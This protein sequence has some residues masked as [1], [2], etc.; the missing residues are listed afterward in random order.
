MNVLKLNN[1]AVNLGAATAV[2]PFCIGRE[3]VAVNFTAGAL[4]VQG[5]DDGTNYTT[6]VTVPTI[7][8]IQIPALPRYVKV[9]TAADVYLLGGV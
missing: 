7:G 8:M 9:S 5:S 6:L 4:V 1:T 3:A 2:T